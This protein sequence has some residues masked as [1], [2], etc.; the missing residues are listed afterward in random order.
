MHQ[1]LSELD[2]FCRRYEE[3]HV[4]LLFFWDVVGG[5]LGSMS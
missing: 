4:G 3:K 5:R 2:K 1:V